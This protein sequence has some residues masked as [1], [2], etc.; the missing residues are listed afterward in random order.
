MKGGRGG[1]GNYIYKILCSEN[2]GRPFQLSVQRTMRAF[3][4]I[5]SENYQLSVQRTVI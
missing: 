1:P 2:C 4:V 5:C 3:T